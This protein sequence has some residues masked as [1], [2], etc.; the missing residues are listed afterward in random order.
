MPFKAPSPSGPPEASLVSPLPFLAEP[1]A[2]GLAAALEGPGCC[3]V[4]P[5]VDDEI[6]LAEV[7][8]AR[9]AGGMALAVTAHQAI[10]S[11]LAFVFT[12]ALAR[13]LGLAAERTDAIATALQEALANA[14]MHGSLEM[15]GFSRE[16]TDAFLHFSETATARLADPAFGGRAVVVAARWTAADIEIAVLDRGRGYLSEDLA[17]RPWREASG[18]GLTIIADLADQVSFSARGSRIAMRFHR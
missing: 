4:E 13:R 9:A 10:G 12:S 1:G 7:T 14:V 16:S 6:A 17:S 8:A 2:G 18:R 15:S 11:D 5:G 3:A